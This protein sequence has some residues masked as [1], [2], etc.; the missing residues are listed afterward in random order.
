MK[1]QDDPA[2]TATT[3]TNE[4]QNNQEERGEQGD[5]HQQPESNASLD[6]EDAFMMKMTL[7]CSCKMKRLPHQREI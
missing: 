4:N 3:N 1:M 5:L 6:E 7:R 2:T